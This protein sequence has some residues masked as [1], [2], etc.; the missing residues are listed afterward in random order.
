MK[1]LYHHRI[2]S[3]DGQY[4]H[5][6]E[7][8]KA[9]RAEGH[10]V[11]LVGPKAV[12]SEEFGTD[13]G[14]VAWLK[15]ALPQAVY[16]CMELAYS[17][18]D[19]L[20]LAQAIKD[21]KPDCIYERYNLFLPSGIWAKRR[22]NLPLL[23]EINAPLYQERK[24][25]DGLALEKLACWSECYCWTKADYVLPVTKVLGDYVTAAGASQERVRVIPNAIDRA[26]FSK[27]P[28]KEIAK[29]SLGLNGLV[30][31]FVGFVREWHGLDKIVALMTLPWLQEVNLL[32]V[33]DGPACAQ[34]RVQA[35]DLGI[36]ERVTITGVV[37]RHQIPAHVAAFDI[38][39]QPDVVDYASPLKVFEYLTLGKAI[40]AP[41]KANIREILLDKKNA[42]LF[43]PGDQHSL[44]A[45]IKSLVT[46]ESLRTALSSEAL[47]TIDEQNISWQHNAVRVTD[48]FQRLLGNKAEVGVVNTQDA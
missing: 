37:Q 24:Q 3:K 39:L 36:V 30:L 1:I 21:F 40:I 11:L 5:L 8:V 12:E 38:A 10:Q 28:S 22:F 46:D 26:E 41:D 13:A 2:R 14:L 34:I 31:G 47:Q 4:V 27:A 33:G 45:C 19:Y 32:I 18:F 6:E 44:E 48:L 42:L 23:L 15:R 29:Q 9:L 16:E 25:H 7:L 17:L 20:R 35:R 43:S